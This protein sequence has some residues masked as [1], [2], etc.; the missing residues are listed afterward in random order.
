MSLLLNPGTEPAVPPIPGLANT[1]FWAN[2][3]A[4]ATTEAPAS[5][6][7][8]G[9]GPVASEFAQVFARF[10]TSVT[11]LVRSRLLSHDEP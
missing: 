8:L 5:L 7:V 10:G 2:R 1:P 9:G 6:M 4:V 11:M 3:D